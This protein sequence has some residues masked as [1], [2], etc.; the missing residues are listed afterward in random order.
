[1]Y[2]PNPSLASLLIVISGAAH[3]VISAILKSGRDKMSSRALIDGFS[4]VLVLPAVFVLPAPAGAWGW[5]AISGVTHFAYLLALVKS[6]ETAEMSVAYPIA[7]GIA[8]ALA[9]IVAVGVFHEPISALVVL[10]VAL[11]SVGVVLVGASRV[12]GLRSLGW[13]TTTGAMIAIY[14]VVDAQ[15]VR[16]APSAASYV[17][18]VFLV[19]GGCIGLAFALWRGKAFLVA[20]RSEWKPG[21][22]AGAL[23]IVSYGL[24]LWAYR[25]GGTPKLAALRETSILFAFGIAVFVLKERVTIL[26]AGGVVVIAAGAWTLLRAPP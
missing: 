3:A 26:R 16:A 1:M 21:L 20:A 13:P 24:A 19:L 4:A 5:L 6:F 2:A 11:V 8:P 23:S 22:L 10:G 18:W 7:R 14:T 17:V 25:L 15:G 9:A 12:V